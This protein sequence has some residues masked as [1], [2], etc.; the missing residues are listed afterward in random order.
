MK[1][2]T[3]SPHLKSAFS[4]AVTVLPSR[5]KTEGGVAE[6]EDY[7]SRYVGRGWDHLT[8]ILGGNLT[9]KQID[10]SCTLVRCYPYWRGNA[11]IVLPAQTGAWIT[12]GFNLA[13]LLAHQHE[14]L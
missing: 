5:H 14:H 2:N 3:L 4:F 6:E 11:T 1:N 10:A 8:S 7:A 9:D 12:A 13:L